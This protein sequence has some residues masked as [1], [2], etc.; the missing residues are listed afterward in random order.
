M[1]NGSID[2]LTLTAKG[3]ADKISEAIGQLYVEKKGL[4][5][6]DAGKED[7]NMLFLAISRGI[8]R[9][10]EEKE[11]NMINRITLTQIGTTNEYNVS[12]LDLN[13]QP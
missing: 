3:M 6:P 9:Y 2:P 12:S 11:S 13:I 8:L 10:L 5:L 1:S 7:R 4:V